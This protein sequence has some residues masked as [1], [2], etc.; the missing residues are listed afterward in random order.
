MGSA[1]DKLVDAVEKVYKYTISGIVA[2]LLGIETKEKTLTDINI[3]NLLQPGTADREARRAAKYTAKG[4]LKDY[5]NTYRSFQ[6]KYRRKYGKQFLTNLGYSPTSTAQTKVISEELAEQYLEGLLGYQDVDVI[7]EVDKFLTLSEKGKHALQSIA[8]YDYT[9]NTIV[10]GGNVYSLLRYDDTSPTSVTIV[11]LRDY[12]ESI[13]ENLTTNYGYDGTYVYENTLKYEVGAFSSSTNGIDAY[14][15][16]N[17]YVWDSDDYLTVIPKNLTDNYEYDEVANTVVVGG[18]VYEVGAIEGTITNNGVEDVYTTVVTNV[19]GSIGIETPVQQEDLVIYTYR[20]Y[21]TELVENSLYDKEVTY[22]EYK[23]TSGEVDT[24]TRYYIA[25]ADTLPV[26][27]NA[28]VDITAIVT[29]KEDNVVQD[30]EANKLN[31]MLKKLNL[32]GED[33]VETLKNPDMDSAY[34]MTGI[35]VSI[36]NQSHNMVV[37]KMFDL[38]AA[39]NGSVKI[40]IDRLSMTYAFSMAKTTHIGSIGPVGTYTKTIEE[41]VVSS[42]GTTQVVDDKMTLRFQGSATQY[43]EIVI[44]E[45]SQTYVISGQTM[46]AVL[47]SG[48]EFCRLLIPIDILN[49]LRYKDFVEVYENSLCMLSYAVEVIKIKWYQTGAFSMVL[50]IVAVVIAALTWGGGAALVAMVAGMAVSKILMWVAEA[51]GGE[52][53]AIVAAIIVVVA[54][55]M[56]GVP[57]TDPNIWIQT[58]SVFLGA[59]NQHYSHELDKVMADQEA[60]TREMEEKEEDLAEKMKEYEDFNPYTFDPAYTGK[61]NRIFDTISEYCENFL[62]TDVEVAADYETQIAYQIDTRTRVLPGQGL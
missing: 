44:T 11:F 29:M 59:M 38:M 17:T 32:V 54:A 13:E 51:I 33:F 34:L 4:S 43:Q 55:V 2:N 1:L 31:K 58:A 8:G 25:A 7:K 41:Y 49:N 60:Y 48:S 22:L 56:F 10:L 35:D 23:V 12:I 46:V 16:V 5:F 19:D 28:V 40:S 21:W 47:S 57:M 37:F 30:L 18:V 45:F 53:G 9:T 61:R 36:D 27:I 62:L 39:G 3:T 24:T 20:E 6:R 50:T 15:T 26:Y 52:L 14:M 42:D